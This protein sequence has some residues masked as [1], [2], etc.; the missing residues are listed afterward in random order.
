MK[1][2]ILAT[3]TRFLIPLLLLFSVFLLLRGHNAPGGGFAGGLVAAG[4]W[5][6]YSIAHGA[7]EARL[8]LI[9]QPRILIG[10]GLLLAVASGLLAVFRDLPFMTG[11]WTTLSLPL[12]RNVAVGTPL[13][14]D[15]GVYMVVVGVTITILMT[16]AE[17]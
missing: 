17:E 12:L 6:L 4:A 16:L 7:A 3:A 14:F 15:V 10:G 9:V 2:L 1:S 8:Q 5:A 11:Q 13:L